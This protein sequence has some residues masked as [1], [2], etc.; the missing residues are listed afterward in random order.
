M[1]SR[2]HEPAPFWDEDVG[3]AHD[4]KAPKARLVLG[5]RGLAPQLAT[6]EVSWHRPEKVVTRKELRAAPAEVTPRLALELA[7]S[8]RP[9]ST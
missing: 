3:D 6:A 2:T 1:S 5:R 7:S 4:K 9:C 8:A